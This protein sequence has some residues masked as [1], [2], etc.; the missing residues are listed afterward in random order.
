M[1]FRILV[2][3]NNLFGSCPKCNAEFSLE[4]VKSSS[5]WEKFYLTLFRLKKYHCK[6]CKWYGKIF[7]YS[8]TKNKKK[9][10]INYL[11]LA[12]VITIITLFISFLT[13]NFFNP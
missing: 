13:I 8:F 1:D 4:R 11:I 3:K 9:V 12:I 6:K 10:A 5:K 2:H 7:I